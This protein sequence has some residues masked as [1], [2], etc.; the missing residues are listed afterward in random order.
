LSQIA[1]ADLRRALAEYEKAIAWIVTSVEFRAACLD[2]QG[3]GVSAGKL[4]ALY[5][6]C[7]ALHMM[8]ADIGATS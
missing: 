4:K 6:D 5:D 2:A 1:E 7:A 8:L 3:T